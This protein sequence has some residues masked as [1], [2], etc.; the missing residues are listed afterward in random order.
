MSLRP[1]PT[2]IFG[3]GSGFLDCGLVSFVIFALDT[4]GRVGSFSAVNFSVVLG[5]M[6]TI[7][8]GQ[9]NGLGVLDSWSSANPKM[10]FIVGIM[11]LWLWIAGRPN[12]M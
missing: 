8:A 1:F 12:E 7:P 3:C 4:T 6:V 10:L 5:S 2:G 11:F 9:I